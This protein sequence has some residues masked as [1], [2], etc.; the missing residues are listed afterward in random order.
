MKKSEENSRYYGFFFTKKP[1]PQLV[2]LDL[3]SGGSK[4]YGSCG[5]GSATLV[6]RVLQC[7]FDDV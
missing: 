2:L 4:T 7:R 3:D 5:Y 1:D 6:P